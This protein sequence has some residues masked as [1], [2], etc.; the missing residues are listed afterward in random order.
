MADFPKVNKKFIDSKLSVDM[1]KVIKAAELGR[2]ARNKSGIK[3]RQTLSRV[4]VA[5][6]F[7][8]EYA[9]ILADELN[10]KEVVAGGASDL[11]GYDVKPQ[12]K[13]VGPKYGK[14]VG[15][16]RTH[17]AENGDVAAKTA[18]AGGTYTFEIDGNKVELTKDDMLI[19]TRGAEGFSVE[20]D[21]DMTVALDVTL[22]DELLKEG[23][24]REIISK[25]Q[26]L[27]KSKR[28]DVTDRIKLFYAGDGFIED[29]F[30]I[31]GDRIAKITLAEYVEHM[32][33]PFSEIERYT[34]P[35][36]I[37]GHYALLVTTKC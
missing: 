27:R 3:N 30:K 19:A 12:L 1:D 11:T 2:A 5:G 29:V 10:V 15:A 18:L 34:D 6:D 23:A 13:T 7:P 20:S 31:H 16:I 28:Y 36:D 22:T 32:E 26:T 33:A 37:N 17:L 21:L 9:D 4:I 24:A 8:F 14:L 25:I 35:W